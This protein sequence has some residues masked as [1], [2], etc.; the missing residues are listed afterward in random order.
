MCAMIDPT[1][2]PAVSSETLW[3]PMRHLIADGRGLVLLRGLEACDMDTMTTFLWNGSPVHASERATVLLRITALCQAFAHKALRRALLQH[4][5]ACLDAAVA[6]AAGMQ[7]NAHRGFNP[8]TLVWRIEA[9][10][11]RRAAEIRMRRLERA[12]RA[13]AA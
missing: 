3:H 6:A 4:G 11:Q 5:Y 10:M 8:R 9:E 7:L 2:V 1:N 13:L 12:T